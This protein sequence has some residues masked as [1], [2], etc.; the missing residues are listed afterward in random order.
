MQRIKKRLFPIFLLTLFLF[1]FIG[2]PHLYSSR[3]FHAFWDLGHILFFSL[4]PLVLF[5]FRYIPNKFY[6]HCMLALV[7]AIAL[8][9]AVEL[10]QSQFQYRQPDLNDFYR[11]II[12]ALLCIS[13]FFPSRKSIPR[14]TL[15]VMQAGTL[16]LIISQI[17]P[18]IIAL[19]DEHLA[20]KQFPLLSGF[21]TRFEIQRWRALP[22]KRL[23][24][25]ET[26]KRTGDASMRVLFDTRKYSE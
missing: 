26:V 16:V 24:V 20:R 2:G 25:D 4:L 22:K 15:I 7:M 21:E 23:S 1:F 9:A 12:G 10:L 8:G 18:L 3:S 13:F 14:P 17:L 6:V 19:H 11:D 5:Y